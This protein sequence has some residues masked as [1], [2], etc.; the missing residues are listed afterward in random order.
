MAEDEVPL[1]RVAPPFWQRLVPYVWGMVAVTAAGGIAYGLEK[2]LPLPNLSLVFL[3]AVLLVAM[4]FGALPAIYAGVLSS[5]V[6]NFF[7]TPPY[8]TFFVD[9]EG[10]SLTLAFFLLVAALTGNLTG[11]V[12]GQLI[13]AQHVAQRTA[14]LYDFSSKVAAASGL[15]DVVGAVC[16]HVA[17]TLGASSLVLLPQANDVEA[18]QVAAGAASWG[19]L[20]SLERTAA[21]CA[22]RRG[23]PA[24]HATRV[25]PDSE[26]LF[27]PLK[28]ARGR[29]GVLGVAFAG[30]ARGITVDQEDVLRTVADQAAVAIERVQLATAAEDSRL[31]SETETL[32]AA[33]LSS[34]S[35]DLRTPLVSVIGSATTLSMVGD[36][37]SAEERADLVHTILDEASRLNRFV[38]N[39]LD[40]TRLSYGGLLPR[41]DW[42]DLRDVIGHA[43]SASRDLLAPF[44]LR[45]AVDEAMPLVFLDPVLMEQVFV[46]ILDNAAKYSPPGG[47]I[48]INAVRSDDT[49][50][51]RI[52]DQGSGISSEDRERVFDMFYRVRAGDSQVAGT[53]LGLA[54]CRGLVEA[55]GGTIRADEAFGGVGAEVV[56]VLPLAP[57]PPE[58]DDGG[59]GNA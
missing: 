49:V 48:T 38:Q 8:F 39:L 22:W 14:V 45:V 21:E 27:M 11:W 5:A 47:R 59:E 19:A 46:N 50:V 6:Y 52:A 34:I 51:I 35:H 57:P 56:V 1:I 26:H 55:H 12:R 16:G 25:F 15:E 43:V 10:D 2:V 53:G 13:A 7:F 28:T 54:I 18:L 42:V 30:A 3:S 40:M 29:V 31:L 33:L 58:D 9:H 41:R 23:H 20:S 32:R 24:G 17:A 37:I 4:R 44:S 36:V